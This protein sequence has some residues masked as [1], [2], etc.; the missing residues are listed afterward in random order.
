METHI[1]NRLFVN[2]KQVRFVYC[3]A[4]KDKYTSNGKQ[5]YYVRN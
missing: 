3:Q 1:Q 2:K 5:T 4:S